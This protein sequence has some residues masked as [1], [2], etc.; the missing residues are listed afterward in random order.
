MKK[1]KVFFII[2]VQFEIKDDG[3]NEI[4]SSTINC[5]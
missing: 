2:N 3:K 4:L 1:K 5:K